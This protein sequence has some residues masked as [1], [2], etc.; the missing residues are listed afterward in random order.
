MVPRFSASV[1]A[2][3]RRRGEFLLAAS[4]TVCIRLSP[5]KPP[6]APLRHV[7]SAVQSEADATSGVLMMHYLL[8]CGVHAGEFNVDWVELDVL[9]SGKTG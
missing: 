2:R 5:N 1:Q 9:S 3:S 4:E 7:M 6:A 8:C